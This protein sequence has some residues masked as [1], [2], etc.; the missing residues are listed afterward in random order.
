MVGALLQA[1]HGAELAWL[2]WAPVGETGSSFPALPLAGR[3]AVAF[4]AWDMQCSWPS[5]SLCLGSGNCVAF[6]VPRGTSCLCV[7]KAEASRGHKG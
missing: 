3:W 4:V 7:G 2:W 5:C 6:T 1:W